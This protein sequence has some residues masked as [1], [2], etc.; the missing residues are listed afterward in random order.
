M[1][2]DIMEGITAKLHEVFGYK[3]Y[4]EHVSQGFETPCFFVTHDNI[5]RYQELGD[6]AKHDHLF[7]IHFFPSEG[8]AQMRD[9]TDKFFENL[10]LITLLNGDMIHGT[11]M[12]TETVDDVLHCFVKYNELVKEAVTKDYMQTVDI[13]GT[14]K[15]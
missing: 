8:K 5:S 10:N 9:V 12:R 2:N 13:K 6:R 3:I 15:K 11:D 4:T 1:I 7:D 14:V